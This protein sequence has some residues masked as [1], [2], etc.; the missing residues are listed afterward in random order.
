MYRSPWFKAVEEKGWYW[1]GRVRGQVSL[2]KD[3]HHWKTS[4]QWFDNTYGGKAEYIG[5]VY[6]GK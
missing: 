5:D 6:Y 3:K 1:V 4:Y 2:S